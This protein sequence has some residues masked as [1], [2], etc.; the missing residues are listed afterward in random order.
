MRKESIYELNGNTILSHK[1]G[2]NGKEHPGGH[3]KRAVPQSDE[4]IRVAFAIV[5]VK[6]WK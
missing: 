4:V 2:I 3:I 6:A 1:N 5:D